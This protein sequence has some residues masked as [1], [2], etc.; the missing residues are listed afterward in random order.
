METS[1]LREQ[2]EIR[3]SVPNVPD[4]DIHSTLVFDSIQET[5]RFEDEVPVQ[6]APLDHDPS[7]PESFNPLPD[8][9][10][11]DILSRPRIVA[12]FKWAIGD[13]YGRPIT[14]ILFPD[15]LF[16]SSTVWNKIQQYVYLHAGLKI[17]IRVNGTPFHYGQLLAAWRPACLGRTLQPVSGQVKCSAYDSIVQM[18]QFDHVLISPSSAQVTEM[19]P[20][21]AT[22]LNRIPISAF[23]K[24]CSYE[25]PARLLSNFGALEFWVLTPLKAQALASDPPVTV[26]VFASFVNPHLTGYTHTSLSYVPFTSSLPPRLIPTSMRYPVTTADVAPVQRTQARNSVLPA[27]QTTLCPSS[28]QMPIVFQP[29]KISN[30]KYLQPSF[31]LT[32]NELSSNFPLSPVKLTDHLSQWSFMDKFMIQR[33]HEVN[34]SL[35]QY[36]VTPLNHP[37]GNFSGNIQASFHTKISYLARLFKLWRG[38]VEYRIDFVASKF[39]SCRVKIAWLPPGTSTIA[40]PGDL[41]DVWTKVIDIQG[42]VSTTFTVPFLSPFSFIPCDRMN[43]SRTSNGLLV[44]SLVNTLSYPIANAPPVQANVWVRGPN[45]EFAGFIGE[46]GEMICIPN[47]EEPYGTDPTPM[48]DPSPDF[49]G[50]S[51]MPLPAIQEISEPDSTSEHKSKDIPKSPS[52]SSSKPSAPSSSTS[53]PS[54]SKQRS[55]AFYEPIVS[56]DFNSLVH[57]PS[58][59][60]VLSAKGKLWITPPIPERLPRTKVPGACVYRLNTLLDYLSIIHIG[61]RGSL[62]FSA[63]NPCAT[64]VFAP[65]VGSSFVLNKE[66]KN[67]VSEWERMYRLRYNAASYFPTSVNALKDV[68][69]PLYSNL[70]YRP[71]SFL[72]DKDFGLD[73]P[74]LVPGID[75]YNLSSQNTVL[76]LSAAYDFSFL[77]MAPA[78][79]SIYFYSDASVQ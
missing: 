24:A 1:S 40:D 7:L 8:Q 4:A 31:E 38:P 51:C 71:Y 21:F 18:S 16:A 2:P 75:M 61:F 63:L 47:G 70:L 14:R 22:P 53:K 32:L 49:S 45:L 34:S 57:K 37:R 36:Y 30:S 77:G 58:S 54:T 9:S 5:V 44:V 59:L 20:S 78:P 13:E 11:I 42:D 17:S 64:V 26:T 25:N 50:G 72:L 43:A 62:R 73:F 68:T 65:R 35:A 41:P 79:I 27:E 60:G 52:P 46:D 67:S 55:Q 6:E 74:L 69:L 10:I 23:S 12:S 66:L 33:D 56:T 76:T 3:E 15:A 48:F 29:A 28:E 19:E 39:H